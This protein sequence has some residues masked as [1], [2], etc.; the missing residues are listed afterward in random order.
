MK[1]AIRR[2]TQIFWW[3]G[4]ISLMV[5][6][7]GLLLPVRLPAGLLVAIGMVSLAI[8]VLLGGDLSVGTDVRN[9]TVRGQVVRGRL[10]INAGLSDVSI[11][12][13]EHGRIAS[14]QHGP[15]GKPAFEVLSDI[16]TLRLGYPI[17]ISQWRADLANNLLWDIKVRSLTGHF[18]VNLAPLRIDHFRAS[19]VLG[20]LRINCPTR[21][22][23]QLE[24]KT[25]VGEIDLRLPPEAGARIQIQKGQLAT[26]TIHNERLL[27]LGSRRYATP[28]YDE[29]QAQVD[30]R[31]ETA[32]GDV[33]LR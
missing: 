3:V 8:N 16:A 23:S 21:G 14:V 4:L 5:G 6:L 10:Q 28:D 26:L 12:V 18:L 13:C 9:F 27:A 24:L 19:T 7:A 32:A 20:Q 2:I 33:I 15:I 22:Y 31:I 29:A 30:I 25:A 11:G 1:N 17:N